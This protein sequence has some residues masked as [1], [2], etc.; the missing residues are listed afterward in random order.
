M[1]LTHKKM[2]DLFFY[3]TN[4]VNKSVC[5]KC[6]ALKVLLMSVGF[7]VGWLRTW[8]FVLCHEQSVFG[9]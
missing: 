2:Q 7:A 9:E 6:T 4:Y 3:C 1:E 8:P 5:S